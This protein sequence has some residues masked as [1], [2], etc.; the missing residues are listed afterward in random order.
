MDYVQLTLDDWLDIKEKLRK[1]L[2]DISEGFVRIGYQLKKIKEQRLY[3]RDGYKDLA[4]FAK[5]EYGLSA[6]TVSRF[7]AINT[8]Y[9]LGG[10]SETL[11]PDYMGIGSSKLGEMLT[12]KEEDLELISPSST[13]ESIR[14]L[15]RFERDERKSGENEAAEVSDRESILFTITEE[16]FRNQKELLNEFCSDGAADPIEELVNPSG[17]RTF[18][19]GIYFVSFFDADKGIK[20]KAFGQSKP[21]CYT[22]DEFEYAIDNI[23][24]PCGA[25]TWAEHYNPA[26]E[27]QP[28]HTESVNDTSES[29]AEKEQEDTDKH[30]KSSE[31]SEID[32]TGPGEAG[33]GHEGGA[34]SHAEGS[35]R[36][37]MG[38]Y[39]KSGQ[40]D[41]GDHKG[42]GQT[43]TEDHE[44]PAGS[45]AEDTRKDNPDFQAAE[46]EENR[47]DPERLHK[48]AEPDTLSAEVEPEVHAHTDHEPEEISPEDTEVVEKEIAPAQK[49]GLN[50]SPED[51]FKTPESP[52][53]SRKKSM[54]MMTS[55]QMARYLSMHLS[56]TVLKNPDQLTK[57][58]DDLVEV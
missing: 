46:Q 50:S 30:E 27:H 57:W 41:T 2:Q 5:K 47:E 48:P 16:F 38:D 23:F 31:G 58:L 49:Y 34:E 42:T 14:E 9:S 44:G 33:D 6:T 22:W 10:N 39:E 17:N 51:D 53:I 3:E 4:S 52:R 43:D 11:H 8:R 45:G 36:Q 40:A 28:E 55:S 19:T 25:D 21:E 37:D 26:E 12:I 1:Q 13:R 24:E 15:K 7:M 54:E 35:G 20:V 56:T 32:E 18:R 29:P